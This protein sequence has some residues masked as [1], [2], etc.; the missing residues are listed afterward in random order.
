MPQIFQSGSVNTAALTVPDIDIIEVPPQLLLNGH[1]SGILGVVG[2]GSW[3]PLNTPI[4]AG[5]LSEATGLVG[6]VTVRLHDLATAVALGTL[7]GASDFRLVRV[8]DGTDTAAS[9]TIPSGALTASPTFWAALAAAINTGTGVQRG[10]SL[11]VSLDATTGIIS[12]LYTGIV[13]NGITLAVGPGSKYG[14][15]RGVVQMPGAQPEIY[16]NIVASAAP[17]L[18]SY[19]LTGGT[20][21]ASGVTSAEL[22]GSD[23]S[24]PTGAYALRSQGCAVGTVADLTDSTQWTT[25]DAFGASEAIYWVHQVAW[26]TSISA[27][28][29]LKNSEG[30]DSRNS[31]LMHGDAVYYNDTVNSIIR[32]VSPSL[33]AAAEL[34]SLAPNQ[35]P[36][37]KKLAG[38]V[39]SQKSGLASTGASARYSTADLSQLFQAGIDVICNPAPGGAYWACRSGRNTSSNA[40]IRQDASTRM[41]NWLA[42]SIEAVMGYYVGLPISIDLLQAISASLNGFLSNVDGQKMLG[43][44]AGGPS[45]R[46]VCDATNNPQAMTGIGYVQASIKVTTQAINEEFLISLEDGPTVVIASNVASSN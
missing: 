13:G 5:T 45:Y 18:A 33:F 32:L 10:A 23:V 41:N 1:P 7:N 16:D 14:T 2:V 31:K 15:Y 37:N 4:T 6:P 11:S 40:A 22:V 34:V 20:D 36:L 24:P 28:I 30:L 21:G 35:S 17:T 39:G 46:V 44:P 43:A 25:L 19:S 38:I 27:A 9:A 8:S 42:T 12:A 29:T 26:G 3:G